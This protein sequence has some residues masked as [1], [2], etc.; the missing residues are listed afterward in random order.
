MSDQD[1]YDELFEETRWEYRECMFCSG[2]K[3]VTFL[4][5]CI[6]CGKVVCSDCVRAFG[7]LDYCPD[8]ARCRICDS[9]AIYWCEHCSELLC[10]AHMR[11]GWEF[12]DSTGYRALDKVCIDG[13][14]DEVYPIY[15]R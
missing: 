1:S 13:C 2:D 7:Q 10:A 9:Q 5:A 3:H 4:K 15:E 12:E 14:K 8:C 11:E 6:D